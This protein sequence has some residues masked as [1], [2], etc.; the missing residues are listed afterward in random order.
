[1]RVRPPSRLLSRLGYRAL[2]AVDP[3]RAHDLGK[4]SM[5]RGLLATKSPP[6]VPATLFGVAL[7]NPLGLAAGFDKNGELLHVIH[8]YGFGFA[9]VGSVTRRGGPGNPRPRVFRVGEDV[10]NRMGL[11][12]DPAE[13]VAGR[14][15]RSPTPFFGVNVAKTHDPTIVGDAAIEDVVATCRL[16]GDLGFYTAINVSCPN[17]REGKTFEEPAA[18]HE[19]LAAVNDT[20]EDAPPLVVKL[21]PGLADDAARLAAVVEVCESSGVGG[22]VACNTLPV[23][24]R[25][26]RGG[27]SGDAVRPLALRTVRWLRAN[28]AKP[29]I[30]VGGVKT[31]GH[32]REFLDAGASAVQA[33]NGFVRG[34]FAGPRFAYDLLATL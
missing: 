11:N 28:T 12:G 16:V 25:H 13:V 31:P 14:L 27:L 17:T 6:S 4:W 29:V 34:P 23:E 20:R 24:N 19:L 3:E 2:Q 21:S 30:G 9:E 22:Y 32:L 15:R 10:M 1:M 7:P 5:R 18:L 33:Y 26:G 8:R